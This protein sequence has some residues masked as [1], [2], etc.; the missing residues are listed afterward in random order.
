MTSGVTR[1]FRVLSKPIPDLEERLRLTAPAL[2][3][4]S[5]QEIEETLAH[6]K[7]DLHDGFYEV[8]IESRELIKFRRARDCHQFF[9]QASSLFFDRARLRLFPLSRRPAL[10]LSL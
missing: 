6:Y 9:D 2:L 3:I 5:S 8:T 10:I 1:N 7:A 4:L